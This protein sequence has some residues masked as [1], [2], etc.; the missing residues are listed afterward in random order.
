MTAPNLYQFEGP[1]GVK[2]RWYPSGRGGPIQGG[3]PGNA[4]VLVFT[5]KAV[6]QVT[7][8]GAELGVTRGATGTYVQAIVARTGLPGAFVALGVLVPDAI[9]GDAPVVMEAIGVLAT[10][11]EPSNIG[12]GQIETY[13]E[14]RLKGTAS[15]VVLPD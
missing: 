9:V 8:A 15:T 4:P 7:L 3:S 1:G 2:I 14:F 12:P 11:R 5:S 6:S 13:A 10:T